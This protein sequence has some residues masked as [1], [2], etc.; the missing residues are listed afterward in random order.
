[1]LAAAIC[2]KMRLNFIG[3][4]TGNNRGKTKD[5][6]STKTDIIKNN[7]PGRDENLLRSTKTAVAPIHIITVSRITFIAETVNGSFEPGGGGII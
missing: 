6:A 2:I 7:R 4:P 1:M 3:S 5:K